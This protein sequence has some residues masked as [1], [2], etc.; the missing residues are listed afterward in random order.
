MNTDLKNQTLAELRALTRRY[1]EKEYLARYIFS[2]VHI[3]AVRS[4]DEITPL[5]KNFRRRLK[6]DGYYISQLKTADKIVDTDGTVKH[7]FELC[8]GECIEAVVLFDDERKT[9]CVSSQVGCSRMCAFCATGK[10]GFRR[11]LTAGEIADQI[12]RASEDLGRINNVVYMGMGEPFDNYDNVIRSVRILMDPEGR[13]IGARHIT[14][15]TCGLP[16]AIRALA[17]EDLNIRLAIS[18]HACDDQIRKR[19]MPGVARCGLNDMME[20]IKDYQDAT[21]RRVTFEYVMIGDLNDSPEHAAGLCRL[22]KNV[23]ANVNLV[24]YNPHPG[25]EMVPSE[26]VAIMTFRNILENAGIETVVRFKRG[27]GIRA[28]CGQLGA[29][30]LENR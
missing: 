2:F 1:V 7:L 12:N 14:I 26:R 17:R 9:L 28:A 8:D 27:R 3:K 15:S 10:L 30:R 24:E 23:K 20:S 6:E 4:I 19:I 11:N 22:I 13:N 21:G 25:C 5:H 18:L 16:N 29:D